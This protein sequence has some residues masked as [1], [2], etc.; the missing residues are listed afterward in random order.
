[1]TSENHIHHVIKS[2]WLRARCGHDITAVCDEKSKNDFF[3]LELRTVFSSSMTDFLLT[4]R[5]FVE[6]LVS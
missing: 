4:F 2:D 5:P 1:M 3:F 6:T